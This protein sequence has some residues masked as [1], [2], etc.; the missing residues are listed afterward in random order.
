MTKIT[1]KWTSNYVVVPNSLV[2]DHRLSFE[3]R[4]VLCYLLSKP[5]NWKIQ[6]RDLQKQGNLGRDKTYRL[7]KEL[8]NIGYLEHIVNRNKKS[9]IIS[10]DYIIYDVAKINS[11]R[12]SLDL[13]KSDS[14]NSDGIIYN[15][16]KNNKNSLSETYLF[17]VNS[18][19]SNNINEQDPFEGGWKAYTKDPEMS[20][21][22]KKLS[23]EEIPE[24]DSGRDAR[25]PFTDAG[26]G[27]NIKEIEDEIQREHKREHNGHEVKTSPRKTSYWEEFK[28]MFMSEPKEL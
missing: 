22:W 12:L 5:N 7:L 4:G 6:I 28:R 24:D 8:R 21:S 23:E 15:K 16:I 26:F 25:S 13:D 27:S 2:E 14:V 1:Q 10:K 17:P 18:K 19:P 9:Q 3:A 20:T 11:E